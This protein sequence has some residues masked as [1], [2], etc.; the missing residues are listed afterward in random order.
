VSVKGYRESGGDEI[1]YCILSF[2]G[3]DTQCFF[4]NYSRAFRSGGVFR[5][6]LV[7][8]IEAHDHITF[9]QVGRYLQPLRDLFRMAQVLTA[10]LA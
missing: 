10:L 4:K 2:F 8:S 1:L 3:F 9:C 6:R 5:K 7:T